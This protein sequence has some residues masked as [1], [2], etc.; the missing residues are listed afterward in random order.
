M[1]DIETAL[2]WQ[3]GEIDGFEARRRTGAR[4][5]GDLY[6]ILRDHNAVLIFKPGDVARRAVRGEVSR[7][8][9]VKVFGLEDDVE[10]FISAWALSDA[11]ER[12]RASTEASK[13]AAA[14]EI[15]DRVPD[16]D[17]DPDDEI[18]PAGGTGEN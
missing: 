10:A 6:L 8:D 12:L 7:E 11:R 17:P 14:L 18:K 5:Y 15:L 13:I 16:V 4:S 9:V 2:A 3:R 1:T